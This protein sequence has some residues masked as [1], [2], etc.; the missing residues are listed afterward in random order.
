MFK[1]AIKYILVLLLIIG[2]VTVSLI[3]LESNILKYILLCSSY[4]AFYTLIYY[5]YKANKKYGVSNALSRYIN[6][7]NQEYEA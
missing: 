1:I 6:E 7:I 3:L 5:F 2:T 4:I